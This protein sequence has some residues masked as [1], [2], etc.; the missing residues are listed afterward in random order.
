MS[1]F[2]RVAG[3]TEPSDVQES[4]R[5]VSDYPEA[6]NKTN[7]STVPRT[8]E[9]RETNYNLLNSQSLPTSQELE[10][11][12]KNLTFAV[13]VKKKYQQP[14]CGKTKV[15]LDSLTGLFR[16][17]RMTAIM[18]SSGAG[19]TSLLS[20]LAGNTSKGT[21]EGTIMVNGQP[22]SGHMLK[23]VSGF[24]FQDDLLLPTMTVQEVISMSALLRLPKTI[25]SKERKDR[26]AEVISLLRLEKVS[27]TIVGSPLTKGISGGERKRTAIAMEM[28]INPGM[29]FLDEPTSGLD[30]FTAF[31]VMLSLSNLARQGRTIVATIHQPSTEIFNLFDDLIFLSRGRIAYYGPAQKSVEYFARQGYPCPQYSNPPDFYFMRVLREFGTVDETLEGESLDAQDHEATAEDDSSELGAAGTGQVEATMRSNQTTEP[32]E[33]LQSAQDF[34]NQRIEHLLSAWLASPESATVLEIIKNSERRGITAGAL[35]KQAPIYRQFFFILKRSGRNLIRNRTLVA[36]RLF[37]AIFLGVLIG[38]TFLDTNQYSVPVQIR[39]KSGALYFIAVN[40]F[41][42][43]ST[44]VLSIFAVEKQVFY[45]EYSSGYY[46]IIAYYL[47]KTIIEIPGQIVGP[48]LLLIICYYM[49]GLNPPFSDYLLVATLASLGAVCGNAYGTFVACIFDEVS[50]ALTVA[51]LFILPLVLV[52]GIFVSA[53]P[54]YLNW[55]K[56]ISPIYYSFSGMLQTE[57]SRDFPNCDSSQQKCE[58]SFAYQELNFETTFPPGVDIVFLVTIYIVLWAMGFVTLY[59]GSQRKK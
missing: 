23:E 45:R 52:S 56:Y 3:S 24:V 58:G 37:Q 19:K 11:S 43:S 31:T 7:D 34:C 21:I 53:L 57:F 35:K 14:G 6:G 27:K 44:Q 17:R 22:S 47:G 20:V 8:A 25:S 48:F 30:T 13:P 10:V 32:N 54:S 1:N 38:L 2:S 40:V 36:S 12:F 33:P 50:I 55:L 49:I 15:I 46:S 29:L 9:N 39:S 51:P 41:F 4:A 18:G 28:V 26:I 16:P 5:E 59:W 42:S